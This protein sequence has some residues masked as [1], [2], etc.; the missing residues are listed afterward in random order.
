[1]AAIRNGEMRQRLVASGVG[2]AAGGA[3]VALLSLFL[4]GPDS[5]AGAFLLDRHTENLPYPFTIQNVMWLMFFVGCGEL[6]AR[7]NQSRP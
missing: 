6:W 3:F 1:M 4:D 5:R 7:F 2:L